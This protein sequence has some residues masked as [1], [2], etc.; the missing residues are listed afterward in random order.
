MW[1]RIFIPRLMR[2]I[3][4]GLLHHLTS[5]LSDIVLTLYRCLQEL[6]DG[7]HFRIVSTQANV[8]KYVNNAVPAYENL[9]YLTF[10]LMHTAFLPDAELNN[11]DD[12]NQLIPEN[13]KF[14][15]I[16]SQSLVVQNLSS[17]FHEYFPVCRYIILFLNLNHSE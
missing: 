11:I 12:M 1:S 9:V 7:V 15:C 6:N 16:A 4:P 14:E 13:P 2:A 17:G 10:D 5:S 8:S 3:D